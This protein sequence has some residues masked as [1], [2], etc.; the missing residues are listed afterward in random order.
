MAPVFGELHFILLDLYAAWGD[1]L[2]ELGELSKLKLLRMRIRKQIEETNGIDHL[3]Y[4]QSIANV[5]C[6]H[7]KLGEWMEAQLLQ[8]ELLKSIEG[9]DSRAIQPIK[10]SLA[11]TFS[12]Q[13][14]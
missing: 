2:D 6:S 14:R 11:S 9:T 10:D 7:M 3:Y 5:A 4:I 12:H 1:L 13:G 8:E